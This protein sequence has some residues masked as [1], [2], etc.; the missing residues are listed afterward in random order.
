MPPEHHKEIAQYLRSKF[1]GVPSV[2]AYRDEN[3]AN[4]IPIGRFESSTAFY[5]TIGCS[6]KTLS[7]PSAGFEFAASGELDWLPNAIASSLYWLKGRECSEWPLVCEDVVRCN[8]RSSYRHMAYVPS[9]H[10]FS[11]STG[12]TVRWLLGVPISDQ[13]IAL[14]RQAVEE[15]A[16]KVYPNWLFQVA[17]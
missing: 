15:M 2:A 9:Q 17:A 6:D 14:S 4:P 16:R 10:S 1:E 13:E 8:A 11:V 7:L 3:D 5:S 12:Q